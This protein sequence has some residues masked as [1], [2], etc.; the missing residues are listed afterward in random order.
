M[1]DIPGIYHKSVQTAPITWI[2][3][4][5]HVVSLGCGSNLAR[6]ARRAIAEAELVLGFAR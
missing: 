1:S 5:I 3:K 4:P 2:G 6:P